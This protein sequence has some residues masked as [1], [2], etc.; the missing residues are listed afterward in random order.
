MLLD[1]FYI[2]CVSFW[3][4]CKGGCTPQLLS[5][6]P[7]KHQGYCLGYFLSYSLSSWPVV[8]VS[9]GGCLPQGSLAAVVSWLT[10]PGVGQHRWPPRYLWGCLCPHLYWA[11]AENEYLD[12]SGYEH[13]L[14]AIFLHTQL[15][16]FS[17]VNR[18][19]ASQH[20]LTLIQST[21]REK[22]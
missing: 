11:I 4:A 15:C 14:I 9:K 20:I 21:E 12:I 7:V 8:T 5:L 19:Q 16:S 6:L 22:A 17:S 2:Y 1:S 10:F 13:R 3:A 18:A